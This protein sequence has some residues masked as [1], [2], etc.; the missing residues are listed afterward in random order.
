MAGARLMKSLLSGA[1]MSV[2]AFTNG[3]WAGLFLCGWM[4]A[5]G[6]WAAEPVEAVALFKDRAL[7]RT[8]EGEALLRT[9][10]TSAFGAR[11]LAASPDGARVLYKGE[12]YVLSLSNRMTSRFKPPQIHSVRLNEDAAGQYR[13]RGTINGTLVDFLIDTGA[14]V[15]AMSQDHARAINLDYANGAKGTVQTAQGVTNAYFVT[16]SNVTLGGISV[17]GVQA[18]VIEGSFPVDV[19]LGMSFLNNLHMQNN[20]GVLVLSARH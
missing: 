1:G 8:V 15:V 9:G 4:L 10:E 19:L 6:S 14:S 16:L 5:A 20:N 7:I 3:L 2:K 11:L 17:N 13:V 18:T 12:E